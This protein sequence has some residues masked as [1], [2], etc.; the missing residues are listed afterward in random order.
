[1]EYSS[2]LEGFLLKKPKDSLPVI[3]QG[4]ANAAV[5]WDTT[6][7]H[8]VVAVGSCGK[9][10]LLLNCLEEHRL[11][12]AEPV[13]QHRCLA[14]SRPRQADRQGHQIDLFATQRVTTREIKILR[15]S[16]FV[17]G[18]DH[19]L[20]QGKF[21]LRTHHRAKGLG[22]VV[23]PRLPMLTSPPLNTS[24]GPAPNLDQGKPTEIRRRSRGS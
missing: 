2:E 17:S 10:V 1:M 8:R 3:I 21:R 12:P 20:M 15:D 22:L 9:A 6:E 14:T 7:D 23:F 24:H 16:C 13:P 11:L 4:D 19:E 18:T 5:G